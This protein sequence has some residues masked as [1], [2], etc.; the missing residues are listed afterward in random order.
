MCANLILRLVFSGFCQGLRFSA[1]NCI[2][3]LYYIVQGAA[4]VEYRKPLLTR[5]HS[6]RRQEGSFFL[7]LFVALLLLLSLSL[8]LLVRSVGVQPRPRKR[9]RRP[10]KKE[11][12]R[13]CPSEKETHQA[14]LTSHSA[15]YLYCM[16]ESL[17]EALF[18]C[19]EMPS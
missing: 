7:F 13:L 8:S 18:V 9:P 17:E 14:L 16:M 1:Y 4:K 11:S 6:E 3:Q 2:R 15:I 5:S 12:D 19:R 10:R